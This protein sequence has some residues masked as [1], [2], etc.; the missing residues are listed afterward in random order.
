MSPSPSTYPSTYP[1]ECWTTSLE[2]RLLRFLAF[3]FASQE[4]T[5]PWHVRHLWKVHCIGMMA[6]R[7]EG[8]PRETLCAYLAF[9][10]P[11]QGAGPS[12]G[13]LIMH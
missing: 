7:E 10:L 5:K 12:E 2:S 1:Q 13:A 9:F 4:I 8:K 6:N 3:H 11:G